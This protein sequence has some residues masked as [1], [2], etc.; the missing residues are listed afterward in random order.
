MCYWCANGF[1]ASR[2]DAALV[3]LEL[4][5]FHHSAGQPTRDYSD[6]D[7]HQQTLIGQMHGVCSSFLEVGHQKFGGLFLFT[8]WGALSS[9]LQPSF[10]TLALLRDAALKATH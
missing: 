10:S 6:N 1:L 3:V 8:S 5:T 9:S 2:S 4:T 7:D